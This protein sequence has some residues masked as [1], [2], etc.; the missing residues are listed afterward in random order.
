MKDRRMNIKKRQQ[1]N[2]QYLRLLEKQMKFYDTK[3][4]VY[5]L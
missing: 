2:S 4:V 1:Y 3:P 5:A